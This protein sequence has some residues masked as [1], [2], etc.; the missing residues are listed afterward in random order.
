[1]LP[2]LS[3]KQII[4]CLDSTRLAHMNTLTVQQTQCTI[5]QGTVKRLFHMYVFLFY[6]PT[7]Y[8]RSSMS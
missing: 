7:N 1:M 4:S 2:T 3:S 6:R 8:K 5:V